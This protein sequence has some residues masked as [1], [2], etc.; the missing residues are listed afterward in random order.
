MITHTY[1]V[2]VGAP[3]NKRLSVKASAVKEIVFQHS[4]ELTDNETFLKVMT[5]FPNL[6]EVYM[7]NT[8]LT[9]T[10]EQIKTANPSVKF[11]KSKPTA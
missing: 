10:K 3:I 7:G 4:P 5:G 11:I 6:R 2:D 1:P 8:G 9:L